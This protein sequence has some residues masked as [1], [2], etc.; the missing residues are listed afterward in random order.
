[1]LLFLTCI[2]TVLAADPPPPPYPFE[3]QNRGKSTP[4]NAKKIIYKNGVT[5]IWN[6]FKHPQ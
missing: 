5:S 6:F 2:A 3:L 4:Y 1:M